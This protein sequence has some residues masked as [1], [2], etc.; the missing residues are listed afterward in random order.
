MIKSHMSKKQKINKREI[1]IDY[2]EFKDGDSIFKITIFSPSHLKLK[3]NN[4]YFFRMYRGMSTKSNKEHI[5][6]FLDIWATKLLVRDIHD[7]KKI[8]ANYNDI[9]KYI[10]DQCTTLCG[11]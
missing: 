1:V 2:L 3:L 10:I 11:V 5:T 6:I 9:T 4:E 8:F 7:L